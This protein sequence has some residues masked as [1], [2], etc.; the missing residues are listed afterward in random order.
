MGPGKGLEGQEQEVYLAQVERKGRE[1]MEL[2]VVY[3]RRILER[4]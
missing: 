3:Q 4:R 2:A 1:G